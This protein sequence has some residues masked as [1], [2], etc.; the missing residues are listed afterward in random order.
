MN[1]RIGWPAMVVGVMYLFAL[2]YGLLAPTL[3][4]LAV[5]GIPVV[6]E[7]RAYLPVVVAVPSWLSATSVPRPTAT[8]TLADL[9]TVLR[10]GTEGA[11]KAALLVPGALVLPVAGEYRPCCPLR[12]AAGVTLDGRG[13]V[14]LIGEGLIIYRANGVTVRDLSIVDAD[15]DGIGVNES[16]NVILEK[17]DIGG[18]GDGG[19]DI[20]RTPIGGAPHLIRDVV[21]HDGKKGNLDGHQWEPV[22]DGARILLERVTFRNV[23]VRTPKVHRM[24]VT[25]VDCLIVNWSGPALDVQ[26]GGS[27]NMIR[28]RWEAG[29]DSLRTYYTPTG[30]TVTEF[31]TVWIPFRRQQR[32]GEL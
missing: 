3:G 31:G 16:M 15:G 12:I 1:A 18:W 2:A 27:V 7:H 30:G 14:R 10:P 13:A 9:R 26:L 20:V 24:S 6:R 21:L 8:A 5:G 22:D 25:M 29:P 19:I 32:I 28:T 4:A 23:W 11:L 17:L